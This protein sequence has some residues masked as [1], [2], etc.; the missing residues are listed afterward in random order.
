MVARFHPAKG[1]QN[2]IRAAGK[3]ADALPHATFFIIGLGCDPGNAVLRRWVQNA[4]LEG[5]IHLMGERDDVVACL[6]ALDVFCLA[7]LVEGF[8]NA[9]G[10]AMAAGQAC[11][12]TAV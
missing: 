8:P 10:E 2:F 1:H 7:S 6:A 4:G 11:V 12:A 3:I 9:L 5:R